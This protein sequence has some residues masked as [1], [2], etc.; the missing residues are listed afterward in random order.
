M[1][2]EESGAVYRMSISIFVPEI[3]AFEVPDV[4]RFISTAVVLLPVHLN[5]AFRT[6]I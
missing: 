1:K 5:S 6:L 3:Y 4:R 2:R